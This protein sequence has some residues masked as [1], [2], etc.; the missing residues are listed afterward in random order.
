MEK[1]NWMKREDR[2]PQVMRT[3]FLLF[4][5]VASLALAEGCSS[6]MQLASRWSSQPIHIDG[7]V[8]EWADST[9]FI[10]K[11]G[12]RCGVMN[13]GDYLYL[14]LLS[15]KQG[16]GRQIMFRGM[17]VWFDPNGG[18]K[19]T[20]GLRF[21]LG[22]PRAGLPEM[23]EG[24]NPEQNV[25]R[26]DAFERQALSEFE[27]LG[28]AENDRQRVSRLQGQGVEIHLTAT[29]ERFVYKL[30]IPLRYSSQHPYALETR[31][32][33]A[34]GIGI[35]PNAAQRAQEGERGGGESRGEGGRGGGRGG[36]GGGRGGRM[37]GGAGSGGARPA[38][39][40]ATLPSFW[41]HVQLAEKT[42]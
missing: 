33:S 2:S 24:E 39:G 13:D 11:E 19:K 30:K 37:P 10:E 5:I 35:E 36:M 38:A 41:S 3:V 27:F 14:C 17:T 21:P 12:V 23:T 4:V 32:G 40:A 28:P 34:V 25:N 42:Q 29:A 22:M 20:V 26:P 18:E 7:N 31:P 9:V 16:L 6:S 1:E 15:S 8:A